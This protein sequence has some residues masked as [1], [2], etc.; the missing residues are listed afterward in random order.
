M[1]YNSLCTG[2]TGVILF[3]TW[4][5]LRKLSELQELPISIQYPY[6]PES[7]AF[8]PSINRLTLENASEIKKSAFEILRFALP[9]SSEEFMVKYLAEENQI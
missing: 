8:I 4:L 6:M 7:V 2:F 5:S 3:E 1:L 9:N